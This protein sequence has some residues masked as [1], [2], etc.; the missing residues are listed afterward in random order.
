MH[1]INGRGRG[2]ATE[3]GSRGTRA[4]GVRLL[5]PTAAR[6]GWGCG[7]GGM[8]MGRGASHVEGG[9]DKTGTSQPHQAGPVI[10][11]VPG[12]NPVRHGTGTGGL[13][14][15]YCTCAPASLNTPTQYNPSYCC[16]FYGILSG[17]PAY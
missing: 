5:G 17:T 7:D 3:L 10:A 13:H 14:V 1:A 12:I 15:P 8:P 6:V 9:C 16:L 2:R 4:C 11:T